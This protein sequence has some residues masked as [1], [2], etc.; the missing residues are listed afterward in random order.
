MS[1]ASFGSISHGTMRNVDLIEAFSDALDRLVIK[2]AREGAENKSH[3]QLVWLARET[4]AEVSE[5]DHD[6]DT[7]IGHDATLSDMTEEL[8]EALNEYAP[9]YGYFGSHSGDGADYG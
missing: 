5:D 4:L 8:F 1:Y 9:P 6:A 2:N 3:I 7:E